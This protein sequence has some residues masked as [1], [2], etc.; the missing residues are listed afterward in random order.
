[1]ATEQLS[2]SW[3][4]PVG[5]S[6]SYTSYT[7]AVVYGPYQI[8]VAIAN[9]VETNVRFNCHNMV[10]VSQCEEACTNIV[11]WAIMIQQ[12]REVTGT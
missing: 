1:M 5:I 10:S 4:T 12:W 11:F 9:S 2:Y 8:V 7:M 6:I 3:I